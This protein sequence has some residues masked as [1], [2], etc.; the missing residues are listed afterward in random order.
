MRT[1]STP[2]PRP[3]EGSLR[4]LGVETI[5]LYYLHHRSDDTPIEETIGAMAELRQAG[6]IRLLGLSNVTA[7]DIRRAQATHPFAAVQEAWSLSGRMVE[8]IL[9]LLQQH[10]ITLVAHSPMGH[11]DMGTDW[12][13]R[14]FAAS[15]WIGITPAQIALACVHNRGRQLGH[16]YDNIAASQVTLD[17][18]TMAELTTSDPDPAGRDI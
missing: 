7:E 1:G 17:D 5:D 10:D 14:L 15:E 4:R 18:A 12:A 11:G 13:A 3:V 8:S 2:R 6:K 16:L 9:P